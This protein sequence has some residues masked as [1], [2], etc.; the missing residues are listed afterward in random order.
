MSRLERCED[1]ENMTETSVMLEL[2][3][4]EEDR[5]SSLEF[6]PRENMTRVEFWARGGMQETCGTVT[7]QWLEFTNYNH[8]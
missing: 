8:A 2:E 7:A 4:V 1:E 3:E 5:G 6:P